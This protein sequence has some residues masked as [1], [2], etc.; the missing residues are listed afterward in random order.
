M[1]LTVF[2]SRDVDVRL[3]GGDSKELFS[4]GSMTQQHKAVYKFY[5]FIKIE[6]TAGGDVN[7]VESDKVLLNTKY[8]DLTGAQR[9]HDLSLYRGPPKDP[10]AK[11]NRLFKEGNHF[12]SYAY[13]TQRGHTY[14]FAMRQGA[15]KR[16]MKY[17]APLTINNNYKFSC[18]RM[19]KITIKN[20]LAI[21][22]FYSFIFYILKFPG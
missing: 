10:V 13:L 20:Q 11:E 7:K 8:V 14:Q 19:A 3:N 17:L 21:P 12:I 15:Y 2:R 18:V 22:I 1:P 5:A 9:E 4:I 6:Y 16:T